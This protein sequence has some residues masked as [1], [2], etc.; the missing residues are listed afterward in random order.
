MYLYLLCMYID[1]LSSTPKHCAIFYNSTE[2][3]IYSVSLALSNHMSHSVLM[4][5]LATISTAVTNAFGGAHG[6]NAFETALPGGTGGAVSGARQNHGRKLLIPWEYSNII[7]SYYDTPGSPKL[8]QRVDEKFP[9]SKGPQKSSIWCSIIRL[10]AEI[11]HHR[12]CKKFVNNGRNYQPQLFF[13]FLDFCPQPFPKLRRVVVRPPRTSWQAPKA[14]GRPLEGPTGYPLA[15]V[16]LSFPP[17]TFGILG[18]NFSFFFG[19]WQKTPKKT[20]L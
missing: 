6:T 20:A 16:D 17:V 19:T 13:F 3:Q 7:P 15:I 1:Q 5:A 14:G 8:F 12:G 11:M 18:A 4:L 2:I 9:T 10:M